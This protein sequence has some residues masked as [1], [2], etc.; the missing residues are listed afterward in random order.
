MT[1]F[2]CSKVAG[3]AIKKLL[4]ALLFVV[5]CVFTWTAPLY[6]QGGTG[7]FEGQEYVESFIGDMPLLFAVGHGGWK[8]LG[9]HKNACGDNPNTDFPSD[10]L[11]QN[12]FLR[13]LTVRIYERTGHLPYYVYQQGKR[14]YVNTNRPVEH[15]QAYY[16]SN[17]EAKRAYFG[18][19]NQVDALIADL[20]TL[21][22]DDRGIL[23]NA[24]TGH[25][26]TSLGPR[27]WDRIAEIGFIS[28]AVS[29]AS[30]GYSSNTMKALYDRKGE[31]AL[32]GVDSIPYQLFHAQDWPSADAVWPVVATINSKDL[33]RSGDD[34]W[35]VLPAWVSGYE[36]DNWVTAVLNGYSTITYHGTNTSGHHSNWVNGLDGFQIE[37]NYTREGGIS[38]RETDT[39]FN[40]DGPYYQLDTLLATRLLDDLIDAILYSLEVNY[41]WTPGGSYNVI[42]DN[43]RAG[44][45]TT[46][47]WP[48]SS[49]EG[50]WG[51]TGSLYADT[52][53][54]TATWTPDLENAGNYE[55]FVRWTKTEGRTS[56]A[57]YTV[58]YS[59]GS[60]NFIMDQTGDQ[61]AKW[62]Y[63]GKFAFDA[64][65]GGSV[66]LESSDD[67]STSADAVLFRMVQEP[68]QA[69]AMA[70]PTVGRAP[71][72]VTFVGSESTDVDG[73]IVH[74]GWGFDDGT[75]GS[76]IT[77]THQ[78]TQA[79]EYEVKL[80]VTDNT[81]RRGSDSVLIN[82]LRPLMPGE[83]IIDNL[84]DSGFSTTGQW[85][86]S[87]ASGEYA[88][89]SV[90]ANEDDGATAI[91][92]PNLSEP[93]IYL[94]YGWW[95]SYPTRAQNAPYTIVYTQGSDV[96]R[97]NQRQNAGQWTLLG[98][99][100]FSAGTDG[101]VLVT[102]EVGDGTST[103]ADAV[104]FLKVD[105]AVELPLILRS[106]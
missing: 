90:V 73:Q 30:L 5:F 92:R 81:G 51:L 85:Y 55:V 47:T 46:G 28:S 79:G 22:G 26:E 82:V 2:G 21:Y 35:H 72:A 74:Y 48:E 102:R 65:T 59:G 77:A 104:R 96:V 97:V 61:D 10:P 89:S 36:T 53:G 88:G 45:T 15:T 83:Y 52:E 20:E 75:V 25:L 39:E 78:F 62:V 101:Y 76:G 23:I 27:P 63:L 11:L 42:V 98:I 71:L 86:E 60:Q 14:N 67:G 7:D 58:N 41:D 33:A 12:Y 87:D 95:V 80:T 8:T 91:W 70:E 99:Y 93:G 3:M 38:L 29:D 16:A 49:G 50:S 43:G 1:D 24:H 6:A 9:E 32:R 84:L 4:L 54:L 103:S 56:E 105:Y 68:P 94:V 57:H 34:A 31:A 40:P 64:G 37:I 17:E 13:I 106:H 18:F 69:V 100:R 19:H 66:V 44:F